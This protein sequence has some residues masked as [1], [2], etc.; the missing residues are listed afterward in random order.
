MLP[1]IVPLEGK[2]FDDIVG[3]LYWCQ[4]IV[5]K[6]RARDSI[7]IACPCMYVLGLPRIFRGLIDVPP[8]PPKYPSSFPRPYLVAPMPP[9]KSCL[10]GWLWMGQESLWCYLERKPVEL[11]LVRIV[12]TC[13]HFL[14]WAFLWDLY[15]KRIFT[16]SLTQPCPP[17][18][19]RKALT[20]WN[21]I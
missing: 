15:W 6:E 16:L 18:T 19:V 2:I 17:P 1:S 5:T 10:Q 7:G 20:P 14:R 12:T 8:T 3:H 9:P 21:I 4:I 13:A 11:L